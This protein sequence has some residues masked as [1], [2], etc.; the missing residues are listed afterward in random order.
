M[1]AAYKANFEA[2]TEEV[3]QLGLVKLGDGKEAPA[4]G[5]AG[6]RVAA[7]LT[8]MIIAK[9]LGCISLGLQLYLAR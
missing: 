5:A 9:F 7:L 2:L 3:K 1:A 6:G 8:G 4:A